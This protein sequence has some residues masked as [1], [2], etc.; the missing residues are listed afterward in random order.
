MNMV[1]SSWESFV[2]HWHH[3]GSSSTTTRDFS[4]IIILEKRPVLDSF[5]ELGLETS[6]QILHQL[7]VDLPRMHI[8][9]FGTRAR[10][11]GAFFH[12]SGTRTV[13]KKFARLFT[14]SIGAWPLTIIASIF[15][16][17]FLSGSGPLTVSVQDKSVHIDHTVHVITT[18]TLS[19]ELHHVSTVHAAVDVDPAFFITTIAHEMDDNAC[20]L[21]E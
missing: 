5:L 14:Q 16:G 21:L 6:A 4:E 17:A 10:S 19:G 15:P 3:H 20:W 2:D 1:F 12:L 8:D 13:K 7:G 9:M 18:H 11:L